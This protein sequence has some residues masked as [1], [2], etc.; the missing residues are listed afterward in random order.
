MVASQFE[1]KSTVVVTPLRSA[2]LDYCIC[3][4]DNP[5]LAPQSEY[6]SRNIFNHAQASAYSEAGI[7]KDGTHSYRA[8]FADACS[9]T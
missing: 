6:F 2:S 5:D 3:N 1:L 9:R 4:R 7:A 8:R